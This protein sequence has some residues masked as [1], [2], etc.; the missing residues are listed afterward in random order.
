[1]NNIQYYVGGQYDMLIFLDINDIE[2]SIIKE[3]LNAQDY[4]YLI[5]RPSKYILDDK[6]INV[7]P[8]GYYTFN[9][10]ANCG[11]NFVESNSKLQKV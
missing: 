3:I 5:N 9:H 7:V 8:I 4:S 2:N 1:M 10:L 11:I 6:I